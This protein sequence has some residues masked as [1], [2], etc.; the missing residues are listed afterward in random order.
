MVAGSFSE[1]AEKRRRDL[2]YFEHV[3]SFDAA[4]RLISDQSSAFRCGMVDERES[5]C[6]SRL[7]SQ[8]K[9]Y[10]CQTNTRPKNGVCGRQRGAF[11]W[12]FVIFWAGIW[13]ARG[14][15]QK[16]ISEPWGGIQPPASRQREDEDKYET[17]P[18][19][20]TRIFRLRIFDRIAMLDS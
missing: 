19:S 3:C 13:G 6:V 7:V 17:W 16:R 18:T 11:R 8:V 15:G 9:L 12:S 10:S 1:C 5:N 20:N 2:H 14:G 4:P